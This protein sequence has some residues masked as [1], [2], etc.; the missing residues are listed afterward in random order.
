MSGDGDRGVPRMLTRPVSRRTFLRAATG[1]AVGVLGAQAVGAASLVP[2]GPP[3][4]VTLDAV[5][6][7]EDLAWALDYD[8]ERIFRFVSDE[9]AYEPYAGALRGA[10]GTL[11]TRAGN[12]VDKTT[13]LAALL[14]AAHVEYRFVEGT[15]ADEAMDALRSSWLIDAATVDARTTAVLQGATDAEPL[16]A[17]NGSP[18]PVDALPADARALLAQAV[19]DEDQVVTATTRMV[20]A[21][22]R[23][24]LDAL[25]ARGIAVPGTPDDLPALEHER[26]VWLRARWGSGQL[27][28]DPTLAGSEAGTM[29]ATPVATDLAAIPD[30][31]RHRVEIRVTV[32]RIA[33]DALEQEVILEHVAFADELAGQ[34]M[35]LGHDQPEGLEGLGLG[36]GQM[37]S[38][39]TAYQPVLQVA[40]TIIVGQVGISLGGGGGILDAFGEDGSDGRDGE[41]TAEWLQVVTTGPDGARSVA[42][43]VLFDRIGAEQ[44]AAGPIDVTTIPR[45]ELTPLAPDG[46]ADFAPARAIHFLAVT[47]GS[48]SPRLAEGIDDD[49]GSVWPLHVVPYLYHLARDAASA[50]IT[51]ERGVRLFPDGP[52]VVRYSLEMT[53]GT[54]DGSY[55]AALDILARSV[56]TASVVGAPTETAPGV[57]AGVL[58]HALERV[59]M[60]AADQASE[61]QDVS[62]GAL[63]DAAAEQGIATI[64]LAPGDDLAALPYGAQ[65]LA[66]LQA[67]LEEGLVA[68]GPAYPVTIGGSERVGWWLLDPATGRVTDRMDDGRGASMVETAI[69]HYTAF[70]AR[71]PYLKL[72]LCVALTIKA[73]LSLLEFQSGGNPAK[74]VLGAVSYGGKLRTIACA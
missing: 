37:L 36:I 28:L 58:G 31:L 32:E 54:T 40:S 26:H 73:L 49:D 35:V 66:T 8:L 2:A 14:D 42:D 45:I 72:G 29:I 68:I 3:P 64:V 4:S 55:Q 10:R 71:H 15:L 20:D 70:L 16:P 44:R 56:R 17:P 67:A 38:G 13:L 6:P 34:P 11:E 30:D 25:A 53:P 24:I 69:Q 12:A 74:G 39:A 43:R 57:L 50:A 9:I 18:L 61:D 52:N 7:I 48:T 62:V 23:T 63:F 1:T 5:S 51:A 27:D 22:H 19:A 33:A 41:A 60:G 46:P 65:A 59:V 21:G 47:T